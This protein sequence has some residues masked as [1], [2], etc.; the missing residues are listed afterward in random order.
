[1]LIT[2]LA[3][4]A[5]TT[6]IQAVAAPMPRVA[7][8]ITAPAAPVPAGIAA[9]WDGAAQ[10]SV[11]IVDFPG[12]V[13]GQQFNIVNGSKVGKFGSVKGSANILRFDDDAASFHVRAGKFGFNVDVQVDVERLDAERVVIRSKGAGLIPDTEIIGR[14]V[15]SRRDFAEFV[16][17]DD[18]KLRTIIQR[19]A[20]GVITIDTTIPSV[21]DAHVILEPKR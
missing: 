5:P 18:P 13:A 9:G 20:R 12:V 11:P 4:V 1:M 19:D 14:I 17:V 6:P 2:P 7:A 21:G 15:A 16:A 8:P 3:S 10:L